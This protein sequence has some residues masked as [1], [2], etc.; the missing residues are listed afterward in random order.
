MTLVHSNPKLL[1]S[2]RP[3]PG[4]LFANMVEKRLKKLGVEIYKGHRLLVDWKQEGNSKPYV[5]RPEGCPFLSDRG[6]TIEADLFLLCA[7][8]KLRNNFYPEKWINST[9]RQ[10]KVLRTLQLVGHP[11]IF[12]IGDVN[13]C[14]S[15]RVCKQLLYLRHE[16]QNYQNQGIL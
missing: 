16:R 6:Q 10:L 5:H 1:S 15:C 14:H 2:L 8:R 4:K 13:K 12:A 7:G 9:T 11:H 3:Y